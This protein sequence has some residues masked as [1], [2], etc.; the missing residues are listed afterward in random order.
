MGI[1][2]TMTMGRRDDIGQVGTASLCENLC[3]GRLS[4]KS[5]EEL[6]RTINRDRPS[7]AAV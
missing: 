3:H 5:K 4:S 7:G 6:L 1:C 2:R